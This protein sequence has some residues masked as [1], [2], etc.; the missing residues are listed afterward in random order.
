[1]QK[2]GLQSH[3]RPFWATKMCLFGPYLCGFCK[4]NVYYYISLQSFFWVKIIIILIIKKYFDAQKGPPGT[5]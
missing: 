2:N 1:M 4:N 3:F 5:F